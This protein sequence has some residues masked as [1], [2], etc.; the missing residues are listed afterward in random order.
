MKRLT[1]GVHH[2][3]IK[4]RGREH[5]EKTMHFYH[6][7]LGMEIV[8]E[9]QTNEG[10]PCAMVNIGGGSMMEIFSN[11]PDVLDAGALRHLAFAVYSVDECVAAVREAG[12]QIT[13]EPTDICIPS[14][15]PYPAR[16]AFCVGPVGEEIEFFEEK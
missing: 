16:I 5:F 12:Y 7:L 11:A 4:C 1:K 2:I 6:T 3:A 10:L 15:P 9:W 14:N 8:R 13:M